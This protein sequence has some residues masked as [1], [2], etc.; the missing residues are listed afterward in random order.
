MADSPYLYFSA[1]FWQVEWRVNGIWNGLLTSYFPNGANQDDY[2]VSPEVYSTWFNTN[3]RRADLCITPLLADM[4][5]LEYSMSDPVLTYEGK[6]GNSQ[7]TWPQ[8][9]QQI[10]DWCTDGVQNYRSFCCWAIGTKGKF[11]KFYAFDGV[12]TLYPLGIN[13][14]GQIVKDANVVARDITSQAGWEFIDTMLTG[15]RNKPH[16][17]LT[18]I[19]NDNF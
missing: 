12:N 10:L 14:A 4:D 16:L 19:Q 18:D 11:V 7:R 2:I 15:A 6:G 1:D 3:G 8:I 5:D 13:G 17:E 9:G